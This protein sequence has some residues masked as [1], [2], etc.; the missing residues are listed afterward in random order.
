M[1]SG[2]EDGHLWWSRLPS[3]NW[4]RPYE[5]GDVVHPDVYG[6]VDGYF[7][8]FVRSIVVGGEPSAGQLELLEG[9][10]ECIHAACRVARAGNRA[11]D[12][13]AAGKAHLREHG[14]TGEIDAA[15]QPDDVAAESFGHGIGVG[16]DQPTITPLDET[17]LAA[18]M[19]LAVEHAVTR[20]ASVRLVTRRR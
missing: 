20:P 2:P 16:W 11:C 1:A 6:A 12:V 3:W 15:D 9:A 19:T 8:D 13:H 17:V 7:Y 5:P 10:I 4:R 18:G 14:L